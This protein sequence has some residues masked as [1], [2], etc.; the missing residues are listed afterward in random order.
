MQVN[1]YQKVPFD[2]TISQIFLHSST[3]MYLDFLFK[4][5]DKIQEIPGGSPNVQSL[6]VVWKKPILQQKSVI[7]RNLGF[8]EIPNSILR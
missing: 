8:F 5:F 1:N 2:Q 7:I 4:F 3:V 6:F